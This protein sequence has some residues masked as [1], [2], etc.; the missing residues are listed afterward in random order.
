MQIVFLVGLA[1]FACGLLVAFRVILSAKALSW[2]RRLYAF[3]ALSG[4]VVFVLGMAGWLTGSAI[5]QSYGGQ[6][7][8]G[9][10]EDGSHFVGS[11]GRYTK[12]TAEEWQYLQ[13]VEFYLGERCWLVGAL[14]MIMFIGMGALS[15]RFFGKP[16]VRI[17]RLKNMK[18]IARSSDPPRWWFC[19]DDAKEPFVEIVGEECSWHW[20]RYTTLE[21]DGIESAN[22][23]AHTLPAAQCDSLEGVSA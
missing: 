14:G 1:L 15:N 8:L 20:T 11:H 22:G 12:V 17:A 4:L 18:W 5:C 9:K 23:Y 16:V 19:D 2:Q 6:P 21:L 3:V 13:Q 10:I 7:S